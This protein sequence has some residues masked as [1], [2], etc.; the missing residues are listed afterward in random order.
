M[1]HVVFISN[2][3][4]QNQKLETGRLAYGRIYVDCFL[5]GK[6]KIDYGNFLF[7]LYLE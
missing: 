5:H 3:S 4:K 1:V 7:S 2:C 6:W